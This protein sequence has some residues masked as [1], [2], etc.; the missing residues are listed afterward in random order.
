MELILSLVLVA[1]VLALLGTFGRGSAP[2]RRNGLEA[3]P[4]PEPVRRSGSSPLIERN[5]SLLGDTL[6]EDEALI[7]GLILRHYLTRHNYE[8][9]LDDAN[10][11]LE[12]L[13]DEWEPWN[14]G[15]R[16]HI[17]NP[18][19]TDPMEDVVA[20]DEFDTFS[21]GTVEPWYDDMFGL[22]DGSDED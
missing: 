8:E 6:R 11:Q 14:P 16:D 2:T 7:D 4:A 21:G 13:R 19:S 18:S 17:G 9:R 20:F 15:N 10:E 1:V 22:G 5:P 12:A 3:K